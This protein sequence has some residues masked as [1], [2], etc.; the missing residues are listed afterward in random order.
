MSTS[1]RHRP[2]THWMRQFTI[3]TRMRGAIAM[4]LALFGVLALTMLSGVRHLSDLNE[5]FIEHALKE[6]Q[7]V[8]ALQGALGTLRQRQSDILLHP[9]DSAGHP[10]RLQQWRAAVE[11]LDARLNALTEGDEDEDNPIARQARQEL[12]ALRDGAQPLLQSLASAA[13]DAAPAME[14][15]LT[16]ATGG[17]VRTI[18]QSLERIAA[19]VQSEATEGRAEF[20]AQVRQML[21]VFGGVLTLTVLVVVPL[22]LMN[23]RAIVAPMEQA[24]RIALAIAEGDLGHRIDSTGRDEVSELL[25]ALEHMQAALGRLVGDVRQAAGSIQLASNEVASGNTDLSSRTE[26]TAGQ[27]QST[28]SSMQELTQNVRQTA[29]ATQHASE[30]VGTASGVAERGGQVVS[31]VV[32]TMG[33]IHDAARRIAD[34]IGTIDGIAFQ[35]NILALNAAVEAARAGEQGRG[36]AVVAG[37]VRALAQRSA[38]AAREI[39]GLIGTSVE[40]VETGTGLVRD[41][42]STMDE[43]VASVQRVADIITEISAA[44]REQS[45]GIGEISQTV[46]QLDGMTQQNAALVE[47]SAAAAESLKDQ[48]GRLTEAVARFRE[49]RTP[50]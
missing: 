29:E 7:D 45:Q 50:A 14:R 10:Q 21:W 16:E 39:K 3:R 40:R 2:V 33:D 26:Q 28:A 23:A 1:E 20:E 38:A 27:L 32:A 44:T 49:T 9:G 13:A 8:G 37:E 22:T 41:A 31:Q 43:I 5:H 19:I 18:E 30:L 24:R 48:A 4:V 35:T 15:Q 25:G 46:G 36:F 47:Q 17:R 6:V 34:I 12:T 42:G 11:A